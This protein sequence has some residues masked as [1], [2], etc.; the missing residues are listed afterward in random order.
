[1]I[2]PMKDGRGQGSLSEG[3]R[4]DKEDTRGE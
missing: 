1:V 2:W 3:E 4:E